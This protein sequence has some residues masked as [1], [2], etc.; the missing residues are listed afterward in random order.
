MDV[1]R[2]VTA[3]VP[4][5]DEFVMYNRE[6]QKQSANYEQRAQKFSLLA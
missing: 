4:T 1:F 3:V 6:I 2:D 5:V